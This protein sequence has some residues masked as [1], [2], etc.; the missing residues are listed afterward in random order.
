VDNTVPA[1]W[2]GVDLIARL[3]PMYAMSNVM[4]ATDHLITNVLNVRLTPASMV[5]VLV[6]ATK[7]GLVSTLA[8]TQLISQYLATSTMSFI[9]ERTLMTSGITYK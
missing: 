1:I 9:A 3:I 5:R 2:D 6:N 7:D 8:I 4:D